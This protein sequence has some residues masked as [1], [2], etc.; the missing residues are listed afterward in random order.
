MLAFEASHYGS[1]P[2]WAAKNRQTGE[3]LFQKHFSKKSFLKIIP[4][5]NI[6][7]E[8]KLLGRIHA[9]VG[10]HLGGAK[11]NDP[12]IGF[13]EVSHN[14]LLHNDIVICTVI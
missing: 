2:C 3:S 6:F 9:G 10:V 7:P 1:S 11:K 13:F 12:V 8:K 14:I 4:N 5:P